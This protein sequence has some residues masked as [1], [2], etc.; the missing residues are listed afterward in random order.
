MNQTQKMLLVVGTVLFVMC[1]LFVPTK[2]S[3]TFNLHH[4][5][6]FPGRTTI[7]MWST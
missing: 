7:L 4:D 6:L 2:N 5:F 3:S 1:G